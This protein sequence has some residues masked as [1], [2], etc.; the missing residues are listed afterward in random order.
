M[1]DKTNNVA[2]EGSAEIPIVE[3]EQHGNDLKFWCQYCETFHHHGAGGET[4]PEAGGHRSGHCH[5]GEGQAAFPR[6]YILR[7]VDRGAS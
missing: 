5:T 6:G 3:C 1:G 2:I 4:G 7:V